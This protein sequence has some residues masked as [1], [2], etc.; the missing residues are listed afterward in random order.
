MYSSILKYLQ[1]VGSIS[2]YWIF[3]MQYSEVTEKMQPTIH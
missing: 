2:T 1:M 3:L